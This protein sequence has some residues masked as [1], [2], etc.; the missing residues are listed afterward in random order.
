[1]LTVL[2][3]L[4]KMMKMENMPMNRMIM[5]MVVIMTMTMTMTVF[6]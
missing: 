4:T 3:A 5:I 1:M 2:M 6:S